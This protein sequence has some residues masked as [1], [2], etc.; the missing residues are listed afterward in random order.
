MSTSTATAAAE[1]DSGKPMFRLRGA[2]QALAQVEPYSNT[3]SPKCS[4]PYHHKLSEDGWSDKNGGRLRI[5]P[6]ECGWNLQMA[7]VQLKKGG[8]RDLHWHRK[9]AE[10]AYVSKG[11][12]ELTLSDPKNRFITTVAQ[13]GDVYYFPLGWQH[14]I[15]AVEDVADD[16][17][18]DDTNDDPRMPTK[19]GEGCTVLLWF[20]DNDGAGSINLSDMI[21]A[22][23]QDVL[24]AS[25]NGI[26]PSITQTFPKGTNAIGFGTIRPQGKLNNPSDYPL[27]LWP[28]FPMDKGAIADSGEGGKEYSVRQEQMSLSLTMSGARVEL[29][30]GAMRELHWHTNADELHYVLSGCVRNIVHSNIHFPEVPAEEYVICA[31]DVGYVP[32]NFVHYLEAVDGPAELIVAFNHPSWATQ[33]LSGMM[34]VTPVDITAAVMETTVDVAEEYFPKESTAFLKKKENNNGGE[35]EKVEMKSKR[36]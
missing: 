25:L 5:N 24:E 6:K 26:P 3:D 31:G 28:V 21:A 9:G 18:N 13:E 8:V 34:S 36:L 16:G 4:G 30:E 14:S 32:K 2:A 15:Q 22:Y 12:C 20:D 17:F 27:D 33:G 23:P 29:E 11:K 35:E 10:W 7:E 19:G 1:Q